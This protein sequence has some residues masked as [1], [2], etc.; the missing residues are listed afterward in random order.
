MRLFWIQHYTVFTTRAACLEGEPPL[1]KEDCISQ[2]SHK[3][4]KCEKLWCSSRQFN[5]IAEE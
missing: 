1:W 4:A 3:A 5:E 2:S